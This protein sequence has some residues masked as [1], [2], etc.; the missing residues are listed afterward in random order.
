MTLCRT[1][2]RVAQESELDGN[3]WRLYEY[4][5]RHFLGTVSGNC[6]YKKTKLTFDIAGET[7]TC[8]GKRIISAG[9]YNVMPWLRMN[10]TELPDMTGISSCRVAETSLKIGQTAPPGYLTES[11]LI[12]LVS[13][14]PQSEP[15]I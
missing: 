14:H 7:F 13:Y 3:N 11:E 2:M 8:S 1:P 4:I 9:F 10:E 5:T 12:G 15:H 6:K